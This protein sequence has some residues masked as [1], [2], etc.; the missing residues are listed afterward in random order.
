MAYAGITRGYKAGGF[1]ASNSLA[2]DL[3]EYDPEWGRAFWTGTVAASCDHERML[4]SV[5]VPVLFTHHFRHVDPESGALMGAISD[6]QAARVRALLADAGV[7]VDYR[8]FE[9]MGH[10][11]HGQDP[12]LFTE[13]LAGWAGTLG[14]TR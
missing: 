13:T 14:D 3:R 7:A 2:P 10:S 12:R 5:K 6:V 11:M 9:T 4:S 1:N 8:S